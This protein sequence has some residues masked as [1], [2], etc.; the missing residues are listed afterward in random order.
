M[1]SDA[2]SFPPTGERPSPG[3]QIEEDENAEEELQ[4]TRKRLAI[5]TAY[6]F[7]T[8]SILARITI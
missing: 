6:V 3:S 1:D 2:V 4:H 7:L 8:Q 5:S